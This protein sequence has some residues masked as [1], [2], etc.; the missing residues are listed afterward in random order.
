MLGMEPVALKLVCGCT[1]LVLFPTCFLGQVPSLSEL[2]SLP[3]KWGCEL[4]KIITGMSISS[5]PFGSA[6]GGFLPLYQGLRKWGDTAFGV[7]V[8]PP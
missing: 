7:V 5:A 8:Q 3:I 6:A 2:P 1:R 4:R